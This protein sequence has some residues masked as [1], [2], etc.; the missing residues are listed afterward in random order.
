MKAPTPTQATPR[1]YP[2]S[3]LPAF[4]D[5]ITGAA[6]SVRDQLHNLALRAIGTA[7]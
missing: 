1:F 2:I 6:E 3:F 7:L 4:D 5:A